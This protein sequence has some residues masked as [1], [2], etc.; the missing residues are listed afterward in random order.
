MLGVLVEGPP[1]KRVKR[2]RQAIADVVKVEDDGQLQ[3]SASH[4]QDVAASIF[5]GFSLLNAPGQ[6]RAGASRQSADHNLPAGP[7]LG[8]QAITPARMAPMTPARVAA[9]PRPATESPVKTDGPFG[10]QIVMPDIPNASETMPPDAAGERDSRLTTPGS[11]QRRKGGQGVQGQGRGRKKRNLVSEAKRVA[12][13]F[14]T[15]TADDKSFFGLGA[16]TMI[17]WMG[18]L[19]KD[20][21]E[22]LPVCESEADFQELE[23]T[24]KIVNVI[25][26]V[27]RAAKLHG[28]ESAA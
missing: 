6:S 12:Q 17:Q 18:R 15:S 13:D 5:A 11:G 24:K 26:N 28:I 7:P 27:T 21:E 20:I 10:F 25:I 23:R 22:R 16:K 2:A 1:I 14:R 9:S 8:N 4:M 3:L 19:L